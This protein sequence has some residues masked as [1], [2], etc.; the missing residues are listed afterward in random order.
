MSHV[1]LV[2]LD[3]SDQGDVED[4]GGSDGYQLNYKHPDPRINFV[5]S[6]SGKITKF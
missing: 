1:F 4:C 2:Y 5:T 6:T 3:D